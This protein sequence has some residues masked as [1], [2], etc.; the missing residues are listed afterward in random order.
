MFLVRY[1]E[2][3]HISAVGARIRADIP[4]PLMRRAV[5]RERW[6]TQVIGP[7]IVGPMQPCIQDVS[8][9]VPLLRS[10]GKPGG[11]RLS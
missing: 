1:A 10:R 2:L 7:V 8:I 9:F 3:L 5:F 11:T 4:G 6:G